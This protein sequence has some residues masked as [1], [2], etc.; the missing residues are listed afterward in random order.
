MTS[1][2][3]SKHLIYTQIGK[4]SLFGTAVAPTALL[5]GIEEHALLVNDKG[6]LVPEERGTLAPGYNAVVTERAGGFKLSG[7]ASYEQIAYLLDSLDEATPSGVDPYTRTYAAPVTVGTAPSPR[8]N[9]LVHGAGAGKAFKLTGGVLSRLQLGV[10]MN[11]RM[12][13][14]AEFVGQKVDAGS[15]ASLAAGA[16]TPIMGHH[17]TLYI[18]AAGGTIGTTSIADTLFALQLEI[19]TGRA[20][21]TYTGGLSASGYHEAEKWSGL[22]ALSVEYNTTVDTYLDDILAATT[23]VEKQIRIAAVSGT[24]E[25]TLDFAGAVIE[26]PGE[27]FTDRDGRAMVELTFQGKYNATLAN[28]FKAESVNSVASMP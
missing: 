1:E 14:E 27:I 5:L 3:L 19:Q 12:T 28:W 7:T 11:G 15:L 2:T 9:T 8:I 13:F 17:V 10:E 18:D 25:L 20:L 16:F 24:S 23:P 22:L 26:P 6:E 21:S 4:Q